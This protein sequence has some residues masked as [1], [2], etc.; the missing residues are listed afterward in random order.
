MASTLLKTVLTQNQIDL[1]SKKK[2]RVNWTTEEI[3]VAFTL[4]YYSKK[5]YRYLRSKLHNPLPALSSLRKWASELV[6]LVF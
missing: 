5:C 2:R 6:S 4:R 1:L 3:P